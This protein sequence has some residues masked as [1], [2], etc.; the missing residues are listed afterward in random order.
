MRFFRRDSGLIVPEQDP[1]EQQA[2]KA[3]AEY[4]LNP[5]ER[6]RFVELQRALPNDR[7]LQKKVV[8]RL[9]KMERAQHMSSTIRSRRK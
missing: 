3:A 7:A 8:K 4:G 2:D 9:R 1:V 6:E 5:V